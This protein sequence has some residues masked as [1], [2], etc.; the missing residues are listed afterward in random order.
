[1]ISD[2]LQLVRREVRRSC[3]LSPPA[4]RHRL[5][6]GATDR[7]HPLK[8]DS[9]MSPRTARCCGYPYGRA[10]SDLFRGASQDAPPQAEKA[11]DTSESDRPHTCLL[12]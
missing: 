4:F 9:T 8:W 5:R 10:L 11:H 7:S 1:M 6:L 2:H 12:N 3:W